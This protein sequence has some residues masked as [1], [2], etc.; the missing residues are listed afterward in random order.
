MLVTSKAN[1]FFLLLLPRLNLKPKY[2]HMVEILQQSKCNCKFFCRIPSLSLLTHDS[3]I[4]L[5][6]LARQLNVN[7]AF[8]RPTNK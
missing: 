8:E 5:G 3:A 1:N 6:C 2:V 4:Q 7:K